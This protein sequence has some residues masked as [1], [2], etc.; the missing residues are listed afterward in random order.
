[1]S[2]CLPLLVFQHRNHVNNG[3]DD[4]MLMFSISQMTLRTNM[5]PDL[6]A[7]KNMCW[8]TPQGWML[9][10]SPSPSSATTA[11]LWNPRTKEKIALPDL[12][13]EHDIP[14]GSKCLLTHRDATHPECLVVL[15]EY[16]EPNMWCCKVGG[17]VHG[18]GWCCYTYDIGDYE[19]P[20]GEPPTKDLISSVAAVQG[21]IFFISSAEDMCAINFSSSTDQQPEFQYFDA[22]M[23]DFPEGMNSGCSWLVEHDDELYLAC[24]IFVGF[25]ADNIGAIHVYK[26]DFSTEAWCSVRDIGDAVFLLEGGGNM[27]ASCQASPLGLKGNQIYFMKNFNADDADLCVFDIESEQ[28]EIT[29]VHH[30]EHLN[31]CR[32]PFWILP[33]S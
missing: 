33:P 1:M 32:K 27:G 17:S 3:D 16:K 12:E 9:V 14:L 5:E 4:Q 18:G 7:N 20:G 26:M 21:E 30:H 23:V 13:E 25:D 22:C 31:L 19:V 29:R 15:F 24:V 6:V 2:S 8:T 28:Q 11:W 10:V